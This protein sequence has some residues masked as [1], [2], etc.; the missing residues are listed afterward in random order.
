MQQADNRRRQRRQPQN[1]GVSAADQLFDVRR[2]VVRVLGHL[3]H[4]AADAEH[5]SL[6]L[7]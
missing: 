3:L 7:R 1:G 6:R 2:K 4:F 5:R